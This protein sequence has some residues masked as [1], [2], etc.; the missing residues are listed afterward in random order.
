M[1]LI[2]QRGKFQRR[3]RAEVWE[4]DR[5]QHSWPWA[6]RCYSIESPY[7]TA[8]LSLAYPDELKTSSHYQL[9]IV[10]SSWSSLLSWLFYRPNSEPPQASDFTKSADCKVLKFIAHAIEFKPYGTVIG[11]IHDPS[12]CWKQLYKAEKTPE[13]S[14]KNFE[15]SMLILGT[16][17]NKNRGSPKYTLRQLEKP[18]SNSRSHLQDPCPKGQ[19]PPPFPMALGSLSHQPTR[20]GLENAPQ[21]SLTM[22][23]TSDLVK[24]QWMLIAWTAQEWRIHFSF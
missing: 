11:V 17:T 4:E 5:Q 24:S 19:T 20:E 14:G 22:T 13:V 1:L 18:H 15:L 10:S 2:L 23:G 7:V 16:E 9:F 12:F 3:S 21:N 6:P 8:V